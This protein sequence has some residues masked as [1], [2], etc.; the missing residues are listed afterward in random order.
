MLTGLFEQVFTMSISASIVILV[1]MVVRKLLKKSPKIYSYILW[2]VL[3][4]RLLIPFNIESQLS[5]VPSSNNIVERTDLARNYTP[6]KNDNTQNQVDV[7]EATIESNTVNESL[8]VKN[9]IGFD[10][11][12]K[13]ISILWLVGIFSLISK[14]IIDL[15]KLKNSLVNAELYEDN[16]YFSENISTAFVL[17]IIRPKIYLPKNL[18]ENSIK[19][20]IK[21]EQVH[22]QRKDTVFRFLGFIALCIHWFNPLVWFAYS[23][24][25]EDM[26]MSCDERV[27]KELGNDI[28]KDYSSSL[29]A[30]S[31]R[32]SKLKSIPLAFAENDTKSRVK[33][34]LNY[35]KPKYLLVMFSTLIVV[36]SFTTLLTSAKGNDTV[37]DVVPKKLLN[38]NQVKSINIFLPDLNSDDIFLSPEDYKEFIKFIGDVEIDR[39]DDN[40]GIYSSNLNSDFVINYF[41]GTYIKFTIMEDYESIKMSD[42]GSLLQSYRIL[43]PE[44]FKIKLSQFV[45][46]YNNDYKDMLYNSRTEYVGAPSAFG[47]LRGLLPL[48]KYMTDSTFEITDNN[49]V[50]GIIWNIETVEEDIYINKVYQSARIA[51]ALIGNLDEITINI[52]NTTNDKTDS[53]TFAKEYFE[54]KYKDSER[55]NSEDRVEFNQLIDDIFDEE[56]LGF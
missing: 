20:I 2:S 5:I 4:F 52:I 30:L 23:K 15:Q 21:H 54:T 28:K 22:I 56:K 40:Y 48:A 14:S 25:G 8:S 7:L 3:L 31:I 12:I 55:A 32:G 11:V 34:V 38:Y 53:Y 44:D 41:D 43:Y 18:D 36:M 19:Y 51:L 46:N 45:I 49:G 35:K 27:I 39:T 24:S 9:E 6:S 26:E 50:N 33:N 47:N 37:A 29:L 13:G 17:G 42:G 16:I 10:I 1:L